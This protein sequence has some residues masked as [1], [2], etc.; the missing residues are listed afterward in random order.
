M[1]ITFLIGNGFDVG[2]GMNSRFKDF[3]PKYISLSENK[4][5]SLK[6]LS[7]NIAMNEDKWSNF[8]KEL[9]Q[10][11][12]EF[13]T[14]NHQLLVDQIT[15]FEIE[16]VK[17]LKNEESRL[18]FNDKNNISKVVINALT[19][20]Y[21][22]DNL[23]I[24]SSNSIKE[25]FNSRAN[26]E[27][28]YNFITFNYTST[29]ENCL[30]TLE[31]GIVRKRKVRG[32]ELIDKIG[33]IA[34]VHG[35]IDSFPIMGVNDASQIQNPDLANNSQ[36]SQCLV[37]PQINEVL[38]MNYDIESADIIKI[39]TIICVY[40]M[41]LGET[42]KKWWDMIL[43]WLTQNENRQFVIFDYDDQYT[44]LTPYGRIFKER[45]ILE[46]LKSY[47]SNP[48]ISVDQIR[49]QIHISVHNNIFQID[50]TNNVTKNFEDTYNSIM[51]S[52]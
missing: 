50:L 1:N 29:L 5:E 4:T 21:S 31:N 12:N 15:D 51:S 47:S 32:V 7:N 36:F 10:Y 11:T 40:G 28:K 46:K 35:Y 33:K 17:Y 27:H 26:E 44:T 52:L 3:F 42:D 8:E 30:N 20:F 2:L 6:G 48:K 19:D 18:I 22:A 49:K 43:T 34:H 24:V 45:L 14:E 13:T 25:L 16:F 39:S 23:P 41:S 38:R 37:K 9:G